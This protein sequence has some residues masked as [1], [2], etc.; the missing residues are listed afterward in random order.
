MMKKPWSSVVLAVLT[1]CAAPQ[2]ED[3]RLLP[4]GAVVTQ[5]LTDLRVDLAEEGLIVTADG[6]RLPWEDAVVK[7]AGRMEIYFA[8]KEPGTVMSLS[9]SAAD[10]TEGISE[11]YTNLLLNGLTVSQVDSLGIKGGT[12]LKGVFSGRSKELGYVKG[13]A[14][15]WIVP[16]TKKTA[17]LFALWLEKLDG[18]ASADFDAV[19]RGVRAAAKK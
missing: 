19:V 12:D 18:P 13:Q 2:K 8:I 16:G 5:V 9:F 1:G 3:R 15:A 17:I 6:L 10:P 4:P 11:V 7:N 14:R